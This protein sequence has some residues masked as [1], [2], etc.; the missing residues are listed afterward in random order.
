MIWFEW[1]TAPITLR[2]VVTVLKSKCFYA[3]LVAGLTVGMPLIAMAGPGSRNGTSLNGMMIANG[4]QVANGTQLV[5]GI[6]IL[7]A[8]SMN[9]REFMGTAITNGVLRAERG[10][11]IIQITPAQ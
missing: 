8:K 4:M 5:N 1:F 6:R 3:C 11:L 10:Q 9:S 7:N 2:E